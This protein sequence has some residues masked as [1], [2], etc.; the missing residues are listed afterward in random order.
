MPKHNK[1][2]ARPAP[3]TAAII[4]PQEDAGQS[5]TEEAAAWFWSKLK[6]THAGRFLALAVIA[7]AVLGWLVNQFE[8]FRKVRAVFR[9]ST[10]YATPDEI[11]CLNEWVLKLAGENSEATAEQTKAKF[12]DDY[13]G[14]GHVNYLGQPIWQNDVHVVRDPV[15]A[16]EWLVVIDMYPGAS[17]SECMES[18]KEEMV[19]ILNAKPS[20]QRRKW[21]NRIGRIIRP[22]EPLCYD[23]SEFERT[24]GKILNT[25]PDVQYQRSL[26]SCANKRHNP[27]GFSCTEGH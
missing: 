16:G 27:P 11:T 25:S 26:G 19:S 17:T 8:V 5:P 20:D 3:N 23:F 15:H 18:G 24:N 12:L 4:D 10:T 22:A 13:I 2:S 7:L 6:H 1:K 14:F 21:D 9:T